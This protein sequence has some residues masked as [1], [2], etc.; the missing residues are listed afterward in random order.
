MKCS[1]CGARLKKEGDICK[2][3]Y[4]EFQEEEELKKD[5]NEQLKLKRKYTIAFEFYKY[6]EL[7]VICVLSMIVCIAAGGFLEA[8]AVIGIFILVFGVLFFVDKRIAMA[9]KVVFY[10]KKAVY[11]FN[12]GFIDTT[13][14]IKY[15]D[16]GDVRIFQTRRQKKFGYGDLCIYAKG[17]IPGAGFFGGFQIKN[18]ENVQGNLDKIG[19]ILGITLEQ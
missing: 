1:I 18:V 10:E 8:L 3:C 13:K 16:I 17:V 15:E 6:L 11:T 7:I 2:N 5:T 19:E 4:K 12:L 9:T 14:T